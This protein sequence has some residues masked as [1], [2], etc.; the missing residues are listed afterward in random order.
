MPAKIEK[1]GNKFRVV[2]DKGGR[3]VLVRGKT[4]APVDGGGHNTRGE[5]IRQAS[6]IN[7]PKGKRK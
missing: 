6:A 3:S 2:E 7:I 1:R 5:A 4:G